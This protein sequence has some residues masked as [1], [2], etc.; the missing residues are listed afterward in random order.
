MSKKHVLK[1]ED[2]IQY[3]DNAINMEQLL[4]YNNS[5]VRLAAL[6]KGQEIPPHSTSGDAMIYLLDGEILFNIEHNEEVHCDE[7]GC[8]KSEGGVCEFKLKKGEFLR[9]HKDERHFVKAEKDTKML[10]IRL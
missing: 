2:L 3:N 1:L 4:V 5:E 9:F 6:K 7:C 10:I 8:S